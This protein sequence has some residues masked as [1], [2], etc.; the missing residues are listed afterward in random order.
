MAEAGG[1]EVF[2][3]LRRR[4]GEIPILFTSGYDPSNV[5]GSVAEQGR[6]GFLQKPYRPVALTEEVQRLLGETG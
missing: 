5:V 6:V 3:E 2:Q 1:E 4:D